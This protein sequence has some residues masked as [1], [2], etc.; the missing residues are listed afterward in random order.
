M[1]Q[2]AKTETSN[3]RR[4][5]HESS[6]EEDRKRAL[7]LAVLQVML[8]FAVVPVSAADDTT[9]SG[10]CGIDG[11]GD[12]L[13]WTL[14]STGT[15]TISGTGEMAYYQ[16]DSS[17]GE[18]APWRQYTVKNVVITEGVTTIGQYAFYGCDALES[19]YLP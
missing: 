18:I 2:T 1:S 19:V 6:K 8:V 13:T 4:H 3:I 7:L 11:N 16:Q 15:L 5:K 10:T 17:S 12:N 14:D 9:T